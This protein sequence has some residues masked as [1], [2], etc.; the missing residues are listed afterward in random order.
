[1][2]TGIALLLATHCFVPRAVA[3]SQ[4]PEQAPTPVRVELVFSKYQDDDLTMRLPYTMLVNA[5]EEPQSHH[6]RMGIEVP[7]SVDSQGSQQYRNVGTNIDCRARTLSEGRYM[8]ELTVEQSSV[9]PAESVIASGR[10][11]Q[12]EGNPLFRTFSSNFRPILR[13]GE[14]VELTT[15]TDPVSG[16]VSK[17][18]VSLEILTK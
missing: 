3:Q 1:V 7:V 15:A 17:V 16:E 4:E 14:R 11:L 6:L 5:E 10:Q 18:E 13:D 8:I 2:R 9:Y 12:A